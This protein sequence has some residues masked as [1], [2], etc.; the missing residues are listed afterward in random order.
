LALE[1][2]VL[3]ALLT[4]VQAVVIQFFHLLLLVVA[5]VAVLKQI[6][7]GLLVLLPMVTVVAVLTVLDRMAQAVLETA[8]VLLVAQR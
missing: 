4:K 8:L 5:V 3:Q 2:A 1:V 7:T 6:V